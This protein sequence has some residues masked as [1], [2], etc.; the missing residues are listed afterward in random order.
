MHII[1]MGAQGAGKGTQAALIAPRYRLAHLST[2]ELFR[3]AVA[4]GTELGL[5]AKQYLDRGELVPDAVTVG[6]VDNKLSEISAGLNELQGAL[7]DGFPRTA[8]QAAGL[9]KALAKRDERIDRVIEIAVPRDKLE[10]RLSGRWSCPNC[11]A[12][13]HMEFNPPQ[14][15]KVCDRCGFGLSQRADDTAEAIK[16]R[17]D[18]YFE[19]TEPLLAYYESR[20]LLSRVD[21]DQTIDEV[22]A[23]IAA[24]I[25]ASTK[26]TE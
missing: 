21:G 16:R 2:G 9:D 8:A 3:H 22:S 18:I 6:I 24:A 1:L 13:Y 15:D 25:D 10:A 14:N 11:G 23:S 5:L 7:F 19:Q 17:L 12:T 20:D 4:N 26:N